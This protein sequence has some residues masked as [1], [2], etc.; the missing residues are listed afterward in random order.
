MGGNNSPR[1]SG[2]DSILQHG[3]PVS[4]DS[5]NQPHPMYNQP[6]C[7]Q[8]PPILQV[9]KGAVGLSNLGNTCFM[10]S[11]VQCLAQLPP[12]VGNMVSPCHPHALCAYTSGMLQDRCDGASLWFG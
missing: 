12:I 4:L 6:L 1:P 10:N 7:N 3:N 5:T 8:L 2:G 9:Q 11:M